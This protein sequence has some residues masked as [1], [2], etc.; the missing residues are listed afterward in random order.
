MP[1]LVC[2]LDFISPPVT[3]QSTYF[4][5]NMFGFLFRYFVKT[6]TIPNVSMYYETDNGKL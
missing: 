4:I 1:F 5:I 6:S 2:S 3:I